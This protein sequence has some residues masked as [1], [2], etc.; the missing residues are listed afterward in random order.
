TVTGYLPLLADQEKE[1]IDLLAQEFEDGGRYYDVENPVATTWLIS[2]E[3]IRR[4]N[5]LAA[6]YLS[7]MACIDPKDSPLSL[8]PTST[9]RNKEADAIG[10]L[11]AY[12]FI[13]RRPAD[14]ALD[15]HWLVHL[16]TRS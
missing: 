12:S 2:F 1:V 6:D 13:I 15:L 5:P 11:D 10:T 8:L 9:S 14:L 16:T 4:R 7:F 3:Q